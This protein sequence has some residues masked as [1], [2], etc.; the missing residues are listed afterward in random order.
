MARPAFDNAFHK[1][2]VDNLHDGVYYV[3]RDRRITYWNHGAERISGYSAAE[4]VGRGCRDGILDHTDE[5][6]QVLC[7]TACPVAKTLADGRRREA[8]VY[9][10]H[11]E[12]ARVP[13]AVRVAPI[14]DGS[15]A[16][17]GAVEIFGD[18]R[19][20]QVTEAR[21]EELRRLAVLD[22]LTE[23]G[24]RRWVEMTVRARLDD[25]ERYGHGFGVLFVDVDRFK[26]VNDRHG[27]EAGDAVLRAVATTT[28]AAVRGTDSVGRWGGDEFV[29]VCPAADAGGLRLAGERVRSLVATG[30]VP[31]ADGTVVPTVSIGGAVARPGDDLGALLARADDAMYRSKQDGRDR[32]TVDE[33]A[34]AADAADGA[35]ATGA[36]GPA[37]VPEGP[38]PVR[39]QAR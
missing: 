18:D 17:V 1:A 4:V 25:L 20:R 19:E 32:V 33:A 27:H 28:S 26:E 30:G 11:R 7:L 35:G 24:N 39:R 23:V 37:T 31:V 3:D 12:G 21:L 5:A 38:G 8:H 22:P 29:A 6:G 34:P 9:L 36:A 2:I 13:V 16:I 14:T 15:G 10:H